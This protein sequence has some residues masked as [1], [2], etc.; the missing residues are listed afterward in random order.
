[1]KR[2]CLVAAVMALKNCYVRGQDDSDEQEEEYEHYRDRRKDLK[3][4]T[5]EYTDL[6]NLVE[7]D[8]IKDTLL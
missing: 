7:A 3:V 2:L 1:M 5:E 8:I 6:Q 4:D